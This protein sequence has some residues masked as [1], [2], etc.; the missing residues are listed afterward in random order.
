LE[1]KNEDDEGWNIIAKH[2]NDT[3]INKEK[4]FFNFSIENDEF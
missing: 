1:G 4:Q 3:T 2:N